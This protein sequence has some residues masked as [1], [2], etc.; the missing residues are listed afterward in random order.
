MPRL[1]LLIP[2]SSYRTTDFLEASRKLG[3]EVT[4]ASEEPSTMEPWH[5]EG[6][7]T[8]D[9]RDP[10]RAAGQVAEFARRFPVAAVV[11]VDD[12]TAVAAAAIALALNLPHVPIA[13]AVAARHKATMRRALAEAAVPQPQFRLFSTEG[14]P[15]EAAARVTFPCVL[16]P[17]FLA[18][19]RG[20]IRA[21]GP[22][23]F[24]SAWRRISR[25]LEEPEAAGKGGAWA[26]EILV[27]DYVPGR[28]VAVEGL[29]HDGE[30]SILALFDKPDPLEG[31]YFEETIYVTPSRLPGET[32]RAIAQVTGHAAL[33]LGLRRGP[34]HAEL[35]V[36][37]AG[38]IV[39][40]IAGRS[41]GGLCSRVLRF[42]AGMSLEELLL[43]DALSLPIADSSRES[44]AAGVM[45][46]PIPA[47]GILEEVAGVEQARH[48]TGIEEVTISAHLG[49]RLI[50]LPEGS[51]YLG[52]L[53]SRADTP[54]GAEEALRQAHSKLKFRIR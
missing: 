54:A 44:P 48:V 2:T 27:E 38:P 40:E 8:L 51:R 36:S 50:P 32:Q 22:S 45:M 39:I 31:P 10:E 18:A 35:R 14:S 9:F 6:F 1:L 41:I 12:E 42:G 13:A 23:E 7:L 34:I 30:L 53:F 4:V 33:A 17:T 26:R 43:R 29:L 25:I 15:E 3:V 5:P 52:F 37:A 19:S 21:N 46:I 47:G 49:Q 20:V 24:L 11:G 28:E 16:K